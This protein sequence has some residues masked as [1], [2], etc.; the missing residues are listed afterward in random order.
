MPPLLHTSGRAVSAGPEAPAKRV[1]ETQVRPH[2]QEEGA[3]E[4][5]EPPNTMMEEVENTAESFSGKPL[6][7]QPVHNV[8][9]AKPGKQEG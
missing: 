8:G 1:S 7:T 2:R 4:V 9:E 3:I 5:R 6:I